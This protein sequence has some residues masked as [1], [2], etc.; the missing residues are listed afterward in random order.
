MDKDAD[1]IYDT[2]EAYIRDAQQA[3]KIKVL[4]IWQPEYIPRT[5]KEIVVSELGGKIFVVDV[6]IAVDLSTKREGKSNL[7]INVA[8]ITIMIGYIL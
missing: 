8:Y 5:K 1:F 3:N 7:I 6:P 4:E 2:I